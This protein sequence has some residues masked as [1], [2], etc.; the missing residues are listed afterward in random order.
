MLPYHLLFY[1]CLECCQSYKT[2]EALTKP[3]E[4]AVLVYRQGLPEES[5]LQQFLQEHWQETVAAKGSQRLTKRQQS[6]E[7][8]S[9][10][11]LFM[12]PPSQMVLLFDKIVANPSSLSIETLKQQAKEI[13]TLD[14]YRKDD[15]RDMLSALLPGR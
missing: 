6:D 9:A 10:R 13:I 1:Q 3:Y 15:V 12:R 4:S 8:S 7:M 2:T 5:E 14:G 11:F